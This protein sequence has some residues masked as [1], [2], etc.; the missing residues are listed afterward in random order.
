MDFSFITPG[1]AHYAAE[2][3]LRFR[4]LRA[5]LGHTRADVPF[6]FEHES[7]HL[8]AHEG[9]RLLGCVL[10]HPEGADGGRLFQM[11]I[12][13]ELQGAGLGRKLVQALEA[14]LARRG[15]REVYLHARAPVVPFYERLG[16]ACHG[17]RF[18][19]V[20]IEHQEMRRR[21]N[22]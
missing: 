2:L 17:P 15:V 6:P 11:A 13:P 16:Y 10:F 12:E 9:A 19:E 4:V 22:S 7:L 14:E 20:G 21:L 1:D 18:L 5:P 3:D 8:I